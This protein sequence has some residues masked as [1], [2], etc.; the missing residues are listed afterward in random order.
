MQTMA[1]ED[2]R[3]QLLLWTIVAP[4]A[5]KSQRARPPSIPAIL[6]KGLDRDDP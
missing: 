3:H 6:R 5:S 2:Y 4:H 1:L